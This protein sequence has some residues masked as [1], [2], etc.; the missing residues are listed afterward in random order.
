MR[1]DLRSSH[2]PPAA[3]REL[4]QAE[5]EVLGLYL[6][7][8]DRE[9]AFI[10]RTRLA[11][12]EIGAYRKLQGEEAAILKAQ[13]LDAYADDPCVERDLAAEKFVIQ[14]R[15]FSAEGVFLEMKLQSGK[16]KTVGYSVFYPVSR[17]F[18][19]LDS[20]RPRDDLPELFA[21]ANRRADWPQIQRYLGEFLKSPGRQLPLESI[22]HA[23]DYAVPDL[24][25]RTNGLGRL[26]GYLGLKSCLRDGEVSVGFIDSRNP[27]HLPSLI[28]SL[29]VPGT[30]LGPERATSPDG[31]HP[32]FLV[33]HPE[34]SI[35]FFT[36][37]VVASRPQARADLVH[38]ADRLREV[39]EYA[40]AS[41]LAVAYNSA[42][43][44]FELARPLKCLEPFDLGKIDFR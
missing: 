3:A 32:S 28:A 37:Q 17:E 23:F 44:R 18:N 8:T 27:E 31:E 30:F 34:G 38:F 22:W 5:K 14:D 33:F 24:E 2:K 29:S 41:G 6:S 15:G 7:M 42:N 25:L 36:G 19:S 13:A 20:M 43:G 35:P 1:D 12:Q 26:V 10:S 40:L 21:N 39:E 16:W 9:R 11:V 4:P